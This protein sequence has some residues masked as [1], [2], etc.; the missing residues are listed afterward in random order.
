MK[1]NYRPVTY[2]NWRHAFNVAQSMYTIFVV[3]NTQSFIE[4]VHSIYVQFTSI[5]FLV[6]W[7]VRYWGY[8]CTTT[9]TCMS[10]WCIIQMWYYLQC[11]NVLIEWQ[12]KW[13]A[14]WTR[15]TGITGRLFLPWSGSSWNQQRLPIQVN[16]DS[17]CLCI[18]LYRCVVCV[19]VIIHTL[20]L[21]VYDQIM[22]SHW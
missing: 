20:Y 19:W 9:C 11:V 1:K 2:H 3:S 21:E 14:D 18:N 17:C 7:I 5:H 10:W 4:E 15:E 16:D 8:T 6:Q 12:V 13:K 22:Y